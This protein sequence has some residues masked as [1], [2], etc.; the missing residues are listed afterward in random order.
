MKHISRMLKNRAVKVMKTLTNCSGEPFKCWRGVQTMYI[1]VSMLNKLNTINRKVWKYCI[2]CMRLS[3]GSVILFT[4]HWS[5][6]LVLSLKL[7]AVDIWVTSHIP[8]SFLKV[9]RLWRNKLTDNSSR[10][11]F[12]GSYQRTPKCACTYMGEISQG[13]QSMEMMSYF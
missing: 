7:K 3:Q 2:H 12:W 10:L 8:S 4:S 13:V 6:F 11:R 5:P 9:Q 1:Y